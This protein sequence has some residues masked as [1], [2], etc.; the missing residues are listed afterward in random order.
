MFKI[1]DDQLPLLDVIDESEAVIRQT[2]YLTVHKEGLLHKYVQL[3]IERDGGAIA[4]QRRSI[5]NRNYPRTL[6]ASAAGHVDAGETYEQA[7]LREANEELGINLSPADLVPLG[8]IENKDL[9]VENMIG[10]LF[11]AKWNA[12][13]NL[14]P[15]EV[16]EVV[17]MTLAD[18]L[19]MFD[20]EPKAFCGNF[21]NS[22][23]LLR[24]RTA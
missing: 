17:W 22:L 16:E 12:P 20:R 5:R 13:L 7:I 18:C 19:T 14:D 10:R 2:D 11:L 8:R 15:H 6:D 24:Q 3:V 21:Y 23:A 9:P 4:L 1:P